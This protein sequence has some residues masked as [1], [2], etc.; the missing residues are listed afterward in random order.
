MSK[1]NVNGAKGSKKPSKGVKRKSASA[2]STSIDED[3]HMVD[4]TPRVQ[5][6]AVVPDSLPQAEAQPSSSVA[7]PGDNVVNFF[8]NASNQASSSKNLVGDRKEGG[9]VLDDQVEVC[10]PSSELSIFDNVGANVPQAIKTKVWAGQYVD[11]PLLLKQSRDLPTDAHVSGELKVKDGQIALEKQQLKTIT[12]IHTWTSAYVV[13]MSVYLEK[14]PLKCQE[15]L[16]YMHSIRLSAGRSSHSGWAYYDEQYRL[17]KERHPTSSWGVVDSEL[18]VMYISSAQPQQF[19]SGHLGDRNSYS[20][21]SN[22]KQRST[23]QGPNTQGGG[24]GTKP[25]QSPSKSPKPTGIC[26]AF[27]RGTCAF[28]PCKFRHRCSGCGGPHPRANCPQ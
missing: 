22:N 26:Y 12:N 13:F 9:L 3:R 27:N 5:E 2:S 1:A 10:R 19:Q 6:P 18:W 8:D 23:T 25:Y 17:K 11:F 14:F 7:S 15:L 28:N 21:H 20:F 4:E 24:N 16:K